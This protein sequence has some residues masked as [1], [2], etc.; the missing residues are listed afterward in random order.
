MTFVLNYIIIFCVI[1]KTYYNNKQMTKKSSN[2][3]IPNDYIFSKYKCGMNESCG[4][5]K[6][7]ETKKK[8]VMSIPFQ[9]QWLISVYLVLIYENET[10]ENWLIMII[11]TLK[12]YIVFVLSSN[13]N[14]NNN[15]K[16]NWKPFS[17]TLCLCVCMCNQ[18]QNKKAELIR[19]FFVLFSQSQTR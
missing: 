12:V 11:I 19:F 2:S 3:F 14:N 13:R 6:R 15:E 7:N 1:N 17:V 5:N 10:I 8:I 4:Q 9:Q 18:K 16:K